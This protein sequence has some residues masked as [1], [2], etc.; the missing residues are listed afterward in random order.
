[1]NEKGK[2]NLSKINE[3]E[4]ERENTK[5][6]YETSSQET[7]KLVTEVNSKTEVELV[8]RLLRCL[9]SYQT[10]FEK[11]L[12]QIS[13]MHSQLDEYYNFIEKVQTFFFNLEGRIN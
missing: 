10:F 11:S 7:L 8:A 9:E 2:V 4:T 1:M 6:I 3:A 13:N 12:L 5:Q